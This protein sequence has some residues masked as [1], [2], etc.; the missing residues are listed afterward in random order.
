MFTCVTIEHQMYSN[1]SVW[2][3]FVVNR[4]TLQR[5]HIFT[6]STLQLFF[7]AE[8]DDEIVA[9][10]TSR[11]FE[12]R[13][14][15]LFCVK[16]SFKA[17]DDSGFRLVSPRCF[18]VHLYCIRPL[19]YLQWQPW[20]IVSGSNFNPS[21]TFKIQNYIYRNVMSWATVLCTPSRITA[22]K[23]RN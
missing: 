5:R 9:Y 10:N 2:N 18:A 20:R 22:N 15:H 23:Q 7:Y 17:A 14:F 13:K 1:F 3:V 8:N 16:Y 6:L 4:C 19:H 11:S 12:Q 21:D